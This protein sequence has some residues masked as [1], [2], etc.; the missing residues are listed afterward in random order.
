MT[1]PLVSRITRF[2]SRGK[3]IG[4]KESVNIRKELNSHRIGLVHQ[5]GRDAIHHER[6]PK[7]EKRVG[8]KTRSEVFL[9]KFKVFR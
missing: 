8:N 7:T 5:H 9:T 1:E 3:F 2:H 4:T 6:C